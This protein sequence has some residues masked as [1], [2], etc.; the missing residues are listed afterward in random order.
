MGKVIKDLE[1]E[2]KWE[3][4]LYLCEKCA[5]RFI[6]KYGISEEK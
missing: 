5:K 6:K 1:D 4:P 3:D 2:E